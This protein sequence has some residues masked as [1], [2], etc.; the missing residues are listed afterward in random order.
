MTRMMPRA[1]AALDHKPGCF[2]RLGNGEDS[3]ILHNPKYDFNDGN[4]T[5]GVAL[6]ARL[7]LGSFPATKAPGAQP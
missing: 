4:L 6:W 3:A 1:R 2:L 7:A 5:V